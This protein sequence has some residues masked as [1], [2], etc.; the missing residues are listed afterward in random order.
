MKSRGDY[1]RTKRSCRWSLVFFLLSQLCWFACGTA[2]S[3]TTQSGRAERDEPRADVE[4]EAKPLSARAKIEK[5][6]AQRLLEVE[7]A[8]DAEAA[9]AKVI[10]EAN[11]QLVEATNAD[12]AD[13]KEKAEAALKKAT[14]ELKQAQ[15]DRATAQQLAD[16]AQERLILL[17]KEE[18]LNHQPVAKA[19]E[20]AAAPFEETL[21]KF[22]H[23][24]KSRK[25]AEVAK[26]L[27]VTLRRHVESLQARQKQVRR[28]YDEI[29]KRLLTHGGLTEDAKANLSSEHTKL[30]DESHKLSDEI[31]ERR[32]EML[33][34]EATAKAKEAA[35][36]QEEQELDHWRKHIF[37]VIGTFV[38]V[39]LTM[40]VL[41]M[42]VIRRIVDL[43]RRYF[44]NKVLSLLTALVIVVGLVFVFS[45]QYANLLTLFGLS[46]AGITIALQELVASFAAWFFIKGSRG[47]RTGDWIAIGEHQGEVIDVSFTHTTLQQCAPHSDQ[48]TISGTLTG[49]LTVLMNN[50]VFKQPLVNYTRGFPFVWCSLTY[51]VTYESDWELA[52]EKLLEAALSER[53]ITQTAAQAFSQ[54]EHMASELSIQVDSTDPVVRTWPGNNGIELT[55]R[56][57][58]HPRRRPTLQDRLNIHV[59]RAVLQTSKIEFA[60]PTFRAI[61]TPP[62]VSHIA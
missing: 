8:K 9:A 22:S 41:R 38:G 4:A 62:P 39:L 1:R 18:A 27:S 3:A 53:E 44:L 21:K 52:R 19:D 25:E 40:F 30:F 55:L 20:N 29:N 61:A 59:L 36:L 57:L 24:N 10:E 26:Q 42:F 43:Q 31:L 6:L 48:A 51:V 34:A 13:A 17:Q 15:E 50:Q 37:R 23:A 60:Y 7:Q 2:Q 12:D 32:Q 16:Q 46:V 45:D 54:I 28:E 11:G 5:E 33:L 58:A 49:G 56:F 14:E 35:A 47:F